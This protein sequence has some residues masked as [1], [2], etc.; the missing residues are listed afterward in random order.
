MFKRFI[1]LLFT[2]GFISSAGFSQVPV[3]F[4]AV[5]KKDLP[6]ATFSTARTFAG[7]SLFGYINGGAELYLEY[8]FTSASVTEISFLGGKYKTE[9]F[10]MNNPEA[11][12][13]IFSVS[14]Y[15]CL[16]MPPLSD[17]TCQT[18]YQLQI[19]KGPY[20]ISIINSA[21]NRSD[22]TAS[23]R[24]GKIITDK[25]KETEID[26]SSWLPGIPYE[27]IQKN[28][29]LARGR[30]G[31]VN[32]SP[33]LE[34]Y[35]KGAA[36]YTAVILNNDDKTILSIRFINGESYQSFIGL[37]NWENEKFSSTE[38]KLPSGDTIKKLS[39]NHLFIEKLN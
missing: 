21:G 18:R 30:L 35:F 34:D 29:L 23:L 5:T 31:I 22:S 37:H 27:T 26:L 12:F 39:E 33:D 9:I 3:D 10:K 4:P 13:G 17:F 6:D 36:G 38:I 20:Y 2:L 14:R 11:A 19:C 8:G 15:R 16:S 7:S 24:I 25:I 28:S 32:G 1:L